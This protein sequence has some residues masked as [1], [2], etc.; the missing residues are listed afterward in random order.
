VKLFADGA[1]LAGM[2]AMYANPAIKGFTTNP[3]L[4]RKAGISDY[5][6]FAL[7]VLKAIPD[8]PVSFEVFA[9]ELDEMEVQGREIATWGRNVNV[10]IPVTNT[11]RAFCGPVIRKLSADGIQVNVTAVFTPEQVKAIAENLAAATPAIVSVFAGRIADTGRDPIPAMK[12]CRRI[13]AQRPK[14]ELLWASPREVL[15]VV[16]AEE[17]GCHIIT[18][19]NDI[20]AKLG[21]FGKDLADYSL[22]TVQMFH[23]DATAAGYGIAVRNKVA[24]S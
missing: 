6:A 21:L 19:T 5:K 16:H 11:K 13:L 4:M 8:R 15:N 24:A 12:E 23:R 10:K 7:E 1:D 9:D 20:L 18:A 17:A 14:A 3:T 22:E 2:K